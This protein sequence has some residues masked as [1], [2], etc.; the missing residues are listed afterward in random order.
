MAS[1]ETSTEL[2]GRS[3]SVT[4]LHSLMP[5][6]V[7]KIVDEVVGEVS[8]DKETGVID[9]STEAM[10]DLNSMAL[11]GKDW[12]FRTRWIQARCLLGA[13]PDAAMW[14]GLLRVLN[15]P[16]TSSFVDRIECFYFNMPEGIHCPQDDPLPL[17]RKETPP[18]FSNYERR[19]SHPYLRFLDTKLDSGKTVG[20]VIYSKTRDVSLVPV[21]YPA[22]LRVRELLVLTATF[23]NITYLKLADW[24]V[25]EYRDAVNFLR[26]F[27]CLEKVDLGQLYVVEDNEEEAWKRLEGK[28]K[29]RLK[30]LQEA[31]TWDV[32]SPY[33]M[34]AL[35]EAG[36]P[37]PSLRNLFWRFGWQFFNRLEEKTA[38]GEWLWPGA[39]T[40]LFSMLEGLEMAHLEMLEGLGGKCTILCYGTQLIQSHPE[41]W[42]LIFLDQACKKLIKLSVFFPDDIDVGDFL[43]FNLPK[44]HLLYLN[45][46][47]LH[48]SSKLKDIDMILSGFPKLL[49][50]TDV[51]YNPEEVE[52][53]TKEI[54]LRMP[55][56]H[57]R[58]MLRVQVAK[59]EEESD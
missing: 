58:K 30:N 17:W 8:Y 57:A 37:F 42:D 59:K 41:T 13:E 26:A 34:L 43:V 50:V 15:G 35:L 7:D 6:I 16:V 14:E 19:H 4:G 20:A 32:E 39:W 54:A 45:V 10:H 29:P 27:K 3:T 5:E 56:C 47:N 12:V 40:R 33:S 36:S 9:V 22:F 44:D 46:S 24:S 2:Q 1:E 11:L 18:P 25:K 51:L 49:K 55:L 21:R 31:W 28:T 23:A 48:A 53:V 52:E 38:E